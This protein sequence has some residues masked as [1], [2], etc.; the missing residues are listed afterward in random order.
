MQPGQQKGQI[1]NMLNDFEK[2]ARFNKEQLKNFGSPK[3]TG[4]PQQPVKQQP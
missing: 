4:P 3:T 2:T 1:L